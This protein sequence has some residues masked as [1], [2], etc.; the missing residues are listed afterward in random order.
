MEKKLEDKSDQQMIESSPIEN[1]QSLLK[2]NDA[3]PVP[4][5]SSS[6]E[7]FNVAQSLM[8]MGVQDLEKVEGEDGSK[9]AGSDEKPK[10]SY[11]AYRKAE[12]E[13]RRT[14]D[15]CLKPKRD[16]IQQSDGTQTK[17]PGFPPRN[18]CWDKH[19][20]LWAQLKKDSKTDQPV[21]HSQPVV[22]PKPSATSEVQARKIEMSQSLQPERFS[23]RQARKR[24]ES[25]ALSDTEASSHSH[26]F[27]I[28]DLVMMEQHSWP[29]V[30][31]ESG[32]GKIVDIKI[33]DE[34]EKVYDVKYICGRATAKNVYEKYITPHGFD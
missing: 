9:N 15:G 26:V 30:N 13:S 6:K 33:D 31:H 12:R 18:K 28:G 7:L 21:L 32:F 29:G 23:K 10:V 20:G 8:Q 4:S 11:E 1:D 3:A 5:D 27:S 14:S 16:P 24:R 17:P 34:G 22:A 19:R 25:G 2:E